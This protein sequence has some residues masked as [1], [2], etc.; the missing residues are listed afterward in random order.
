MEWEYEVNGVMYNRSKM[1]TI[2]S[3]IRNISEGGVAEVMYNPSNPN[4]SMLAEERFARK[5][6]SG[7]KITIF[8]VMFLAYLGLWLKK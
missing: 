8:G 3:P 2:G 7:L 6:N 1:D 4:E 5:G